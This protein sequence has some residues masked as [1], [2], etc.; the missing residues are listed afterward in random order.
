MNTKLQDDFR[1]YLANK[2]DLVKAHAG[3][4][5]VIKDCQVIGVYDTQLLAIDETKKH[6]KLGTFLVKHCL[7]GDDADRQVYHS[8]VIFA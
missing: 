1:Y 6:H 8:R 2:T 4:F 5:I 3:K 7:P